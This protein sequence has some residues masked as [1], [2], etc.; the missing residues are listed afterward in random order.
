MLIYIVVV[1]C[2]IGE[3][4]NDSSDGVGSIIVYLNTNIFFFFYLF[5]LI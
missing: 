4:E 3:G 1:W 2:L 5:F